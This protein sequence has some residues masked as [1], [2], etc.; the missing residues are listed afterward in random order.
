MSLYTWCHQGPHKPSSCSTFMLNLNWGRAAT[1]KKKSYV[2]A[3]RVALV[4]STLCDSVDC[5]LPAFSV[6]DGGSPG[7]NTGVYWPILVAIP[8]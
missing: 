1:G 7:K 5:S 8:F 4:V 3:H 2:C 6:R